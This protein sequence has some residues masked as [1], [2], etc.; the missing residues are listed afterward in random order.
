MKHFFTCKLFSLLLICTLSGIWS[1]S[2]IAQN[3]SN[4]KVQYE[5]SRS[6]IENKGQFNNPKVPG[7]VMF[8]WDDANTVV[9]FTTQG[10]YYAF[11]K[12]WKKEEGEEK[13]E[14]EKK[15]FTSAKAWME[16]EKEER[17]LEYETAMVSMQWV[18]PNPSVSLI[19]ED[20][21]ND[22]HSYYITNAS[23]TRENITNIHSYKKLIYKNI[24]HNIDIE[25]SFH[26]E[27]GIKYAV[28]VHPGADAAQ[29]KMKYSQAVRSENNGNISIHSKFGNIIEHAPVTFNQNETAVTINSSFAI[30]GNTVGFQL[31]NYDPTKTI[32]IDPWVQ[33]PLIPTSH[34]VMECE[35]DAA[36]NVYI[37]GG[38][39]PM[40]LLKYNASG[41]LQWTHNT[42]YDTANFWLG[43]F[44]TD[45]AGNSYITA[46]SVCRL[47]KVN[48]SNA[49]QWSW[50]PGGLT[51]SDEYW[52]IAFNCDQTRLI[53]GGT[54]GTGLMTLNGAIFDVNTNDGSIN[55]TRIVG[56]GSVVAFP[57]SIQEVRSITS[58]R[59]ARYYFL[60]LDTIGC[61]DDNFSICPSNTPSIF[62]INHGYHLSYKCENYRPNNGNGGI[63]AIRAD[64]NYVYTQNATVIEQRSLADGSVLA[65]AA[66]PGGI[67]ISS[68]GQNQVGNSGI[69]I[70]SC[71]NVY[72]GSGNALIQYTS[73]LAQIGATA[74]SYHVYDVAVST[75]GNVIACGA[76][77]DLNTSV[78]T[79]YV[80]SFALGACLPMSL[81]CCDANICPVSPVCNTAPAFTLTAATPGGTWSGA[82]ITDAVNGVF[83]PTS[84]NLGANTI[85]YTLPCGMDSTLIQVNACA[86]LYACQNVDG[87]LTV[88]GGTDPYSWQTQTITQD[89]SA[90]LVG[91]LFPAGCAVNTVTWTTYATGDT[92]AQPATWPIRVIDNTGTFLDIAGIA[93]LPICSSCA[94]TATA[95][96]DP[97]CSGESTTLT[98]SGAN[99]YVWSPATALSAT[100]G[101]TVQANPT[102][103]T[104]YTVT[105]T[106]PGCTG[107]NTVTVTVN[108]L[109]VVTV[110][111]TPN[112]LCP[113]ETTTITAAGATT[114]TWSSG[115]GTG[116]PVTATPSASTTYAVTGSDGSCT[117]SASV[118][119]SVA[120]QPN[121][122]AMA[123]PDT[124]CGG[125][126]TTISASGATSYL[127]SPGGYTDA[128]VV[129]SPLTNTTYTVTGTTGGSCS[130]TASVNIVVSPYIQ[131]G[132]VTEPLW[133]CEPLTVM[134]M[135]DTTNIAV[136]TSIRYDFG[137]PSTTDD[138]STLAN[139]S[140]TYQHHGT[141]VVTV[142]AKTIYHC[143]IILTQTIE[144]YEQPDAGFIAHPMVTDTWSPMIDFFDESDNAIHWEW[145][146]GDPASLVENASTLEN[147]QHTFTGPGTYPVMLTVTNENCSDTLT[148]Y[149][150]VYE[151][152]TFF[153]PNSFT[154]NNDGK[155]ETFNGYGKGYKTDG[156]ELYVFDRWGEPIFHTNDPEQGWNGRVQNKD[157]VC[158]NGTYVYMFKVVEMNSIIHKYV[159]TVTLIR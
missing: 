9:Y 69:D 25:F 102:V 144:V 158:M 38:E 88:Y 2:S 24:Y 113:N 53:I 4:W 89:C 59:N 147:P 52:N 12:T 57:P 155:N 127:W 139:P 8:A 58:C 135:F 14:K 31:D 115:L 122:T 6:F 154:P 104:V 62:A 152:Y 60:T 11:L 36:G 20:M 79:G 55:S 148:K 85:Y 117:A 18:S 114:Y 74:T 119:I 146:F 67:S 126:S 77:G 125:F 108:P 110:S 136:F 131:A 44:A 78:R 65:T 97:I 3:A 145:D 100:T 86:T 132:F 71:G 118:F 19:A 45:L 129:V 84:A 124:I 7:K 5:H 51:P 21:N 134:F 81:Y 48:A 82:G 94:V 40:Q 66:I 56:A 153:V 90:C 13:E 29:V 98:A 15:K 37:I 54:K 138:Y 73:S 26:P 35:R 130:A 111:A 70:D 41:T 43:T 64:R 27:Q 143:T 95:S 10:V 112:A 87:T 49:V 33:T 137:D 120:A 75:A 121:L 16:F 106:A 96:P 92:A 23:G 22:F 34:A 91:C 157:E 46:G 151:G 39:S 61:I 103:T 142:T 47:E 50:T 128:S 93:G 30:E 101:I 99:T 32:V 159:G 109:P 63:M 42:P 83:D 116:N 76:T 17:A 68:L 28:I 107:S 156:F 1:T 105:G 141:Y 80:Q 140:Y 72:V 123:S 149:I 133:G 150:T